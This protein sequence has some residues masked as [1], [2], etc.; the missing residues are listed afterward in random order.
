M[1]RLFVDTNIVLDLLTKRPEFYREAQGLF[2]LSAE[3]KVELCVSPLT[4]ATTYYLL[5]RQ[6]RAPE[7][8]RIIAQLKALVTV[9]PMDTVTVELAL[10]SGFGDFEDALQ[11]YTATQNN[12]GFI[13]TRNKKDFGKSALP[14]FTAKEY[15]GRL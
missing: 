9:L 8:L 1:D 6:Y 11:Y 12:I 5:T 10:V 7:A 4:V 13:I 15:L 3:S 2:T 14:V